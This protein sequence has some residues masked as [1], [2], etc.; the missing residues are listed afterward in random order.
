MAWFYIMIAGVLETV[1]AVAM[2]A[3]GLRTPTTAIVMLAAM[4][5]SFLFLSNA[6]RS[7]PLGAAY[8]AWT[9]IGAVGS[10]CVGVLAFGERLNLAGLAGAALILGGVLLIRLGAG[11]A[12]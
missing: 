5:G 3:G 10:F 11:A 2:K 12:A 1:W 7:L 8:M 6:M 9:G 4:A